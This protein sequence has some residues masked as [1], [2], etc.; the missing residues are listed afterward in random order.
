MQKEKL[1]FRIKGRSIIYEGYPA[2]R[3]KD[4]M[5]ILA[6]MMIEEE[7]VIPTFRENIGDAQTDSEVMA[8]FEEAKRIRKEKRSKKADDPAEAASPAEAQPAQTVTAQSTAAASTAQPPAVQVT[9]QVQRIT[10]VFKGKQY[11]YDGLPSKKDHALF[12][13]FSKQSATPDLI[14][15]TYRDNIADHAKFTDD[16]ILRQSEEV[17][18]AR[19]ARK[20][21][22]MTAPGASD[23]PLQQ[24]Q[25]N[26]A[27]LSAPP[28]AGTDASRSAIDEITA[29]STQER[30]SI[31]SFINQVLQSNPPSVAVAHVA[32][33]PNPKPA[34]HADATDESTIAPPKSQA[35]GPKV[36]V[37]CQE[38]G[39]TASKM[40]YAP[41]NVS[42]AEFAS[43]VE[44]KLGRK[45]VLSFFEGED[46]IEVDDDDVLQM[47]FELQNDGRKLRLICSAPETRRKATDD[48]LTAQSS[49]VLTVTAA[50]SSSGPS[51]SASVAADDSRAV[52]APRA[53]AHSTGVVAAKEVKAFTGHS[54]AV[55]CCSFS[56]KGDKFC[57]ASRDRSVRVWTIQGAT[58]SVMKGGHNGFVLCCDFSPNGNFVVSSADDC[59]IKIW[60]VNTCQK[61]LSLKGHDDKVYCVS[62]NSTGAYI[63]SGSCDRTVRVWNADSGAKQ[64]TLKGHDLAVFSCCFSNTDAGRYVASGSDDRLVKIWDWREN[65]EVK[66]LMGHTGTVWS[67][68]F[69]HHDKY[70]VSASMDH[71]IKLW[72]AT[73]G[74]C[75]RTMTGHNTPIHHAI[76][77]MNDKYILSCARDWNVMVW[78][79]ES[80]QHLE[81]IQGHRNTVYHLDVQ[82][83][84]L[85]TSSL[86][87]TVKLWNFSE[88]VKQPQSS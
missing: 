71:E 25:A 74:Q 81:T 67:V 29:M 15:K 32:A 14:V 34:A 47:F 10:L 61:V 4:L 80:G 20:A 49:K 40:I 57:T 26:A 12:E 86:D 48:K 78:D 3:A 35:D 39:N 38:E 2:A 7:L 5:D 66:S 16:E 28:P 85:L 87:D 69:S 45:M 13:L 63:V 43:M 60:N 68:K 58:C 36:A 31:N 65:R 77:S 83:D 19:L 53:A 33:T 62:Y 50:A 42:F 18:Q 9:E 82:G 23:A 64:V 46:K 11:A 21:S 37:Y 54:A 56:P 51:T 27:Q 22:K 84:Q 75:I 79:T 1:K 17:K 72:D 59:S 30:D 8:M 6:K 41:K 24:Q 55:Y 73:S 76:F 88:V 52:S 70:V 44:K